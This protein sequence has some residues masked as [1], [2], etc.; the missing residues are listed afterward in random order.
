MAHTPGEWQ[1]DQMSYGW[2]V[3]HELGL[4]YWTIA[5]TEANARLIAAAPDLLEACEAALEDGQDYKLSETIKRRL[6]AAIDKAKAD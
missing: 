4:F 1:V 5:E 3:R 6:R 2:N